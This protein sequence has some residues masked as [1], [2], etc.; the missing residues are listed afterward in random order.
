MFLPI[1]FSSSSTI[2][3]G[4]LFIFGF[5]NISFIINFPALPAP[6]IKTLDASF[7][8]FILIKDNTLLIALYVNLD[9]T[10]ST[11]T[12]KTLIM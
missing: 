3:T 7:V 8:L 5:S 2:P 10:V 9:P 1:F 4:N 11:I 12:N 6:I